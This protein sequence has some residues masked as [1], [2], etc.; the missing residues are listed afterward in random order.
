[1]KKVMTYKMRAECNADL[2]RFLTEVAVDSFKAD[3]VK[4]KDLVLPDV[5]AEFTSTLSLEQIR[6]AISGIE[7]GHV[8]LETVNTAAEYT[9]ERK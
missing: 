6:Q 8:M 1:M 7:D 3:R 9:G 4:I 2:G 5:I